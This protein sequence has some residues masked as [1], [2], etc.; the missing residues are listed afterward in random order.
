MPVDYVQ[1]RGFICGIRPVGVLLRLSG[2]LEP[3]EQE[4]SYLLRGTD[5]QGRISSELPY[6]GFAGI[7]FVA[8]LRGKVLQGSEIH[9]DPVPLHLGQNLHQRLFH[10]VIELLQSGLGDFFGELFLEQEQYRGFLAPV[11]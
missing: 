9:A 10:P 8:K 3:A 1:Q 7:H 2:E 11:G 6:P 5:V 4:F